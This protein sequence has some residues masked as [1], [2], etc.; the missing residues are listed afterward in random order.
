VFQPKPF[1]VCLALLLSAPLCRDT[2]PAAAPAPAPTVHF[3]VHRNK[4]MVPVR[5]NGSRPLRLILDS[6]MGFEGVLLFRPGLRDSIGA[7]RLFSA[8]IPGAGGGPPSEAFVA[9]SLTLQV[10]DVRIGGQR[11]IVLADTAMAHGPNDGVIGYTLL[12]RYTLE[13]DYGRRVITMHDSS[14]F[15]PAPGWTALPLTFNE[16]NLPFLEVAAVVKAG[17]PAKYKAYVDFASSETIEFLVRP[18]MRFEVPADAKEVVLGRG[19]SGVI[20][21]KRAAIAKLVIGGHVL[22]GLTAAFTP[23][24]IR[25]K[26]QSADAVLSNGALCRFDVVFDYARKRLLVRP[27]NHRPDALD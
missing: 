10:G 7:T 6:G 1:A 5:V 22:K 9:D 2:A 20:H 26:A 25:S 14:T 17:P 18:G 13:L 4:V 12:G 8:R 15:R 3:D 24:E 27:N 23:A 21:G 19:L 16:R 11:V